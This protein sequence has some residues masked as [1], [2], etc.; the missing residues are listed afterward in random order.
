[1][2]YNCP[3]AEKPEPGVEM[4]GRGDDRMGN[5]RF[6]DF[7]K[8]AAEGKL[9]YRLKQALLGGFTGAVIAGSAVGA[10]SAD[11]LVE[12]DGVTV[13][14]SDAGV[15]VDTDDD[16]VDDDDDGVVVVTDDVFVDT[17]GDGVVVRTDDG[18]IILT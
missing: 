7:A 12:T 14:T 17:T 5:R 15:V 18:D 1:M 2:L 13:N 8:A 3:G 6:D 10:A 16:D 9:R 11:V 4:L